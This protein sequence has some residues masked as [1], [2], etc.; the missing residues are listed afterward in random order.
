MN[1]IEAFKTGKVVGRETEPFAHFNSAEYSMS[2]VY[3]MTPEDILADDWEVITFET[4][5]TQVNLDS[6]KAACAKIEHL[7]P[8]TAALIA[9][10]LGLENL[11]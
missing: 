1:I 10:H 9:K 11:T 6:L 3:E 7:P 4:N 2:D 8:G 5:S